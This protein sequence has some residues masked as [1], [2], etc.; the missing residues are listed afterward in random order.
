[1]PP[2][3]A[4]EVVAG[5]GTI[6]LEL[7]EELPELTTVLVPAGGG[8]L[9]AGVAV[10]VK[11]SRPDVRIVGVQTAAMPGLLA[12]RDGRRAR[13]GTAD[14]HRGGWRRRRRALGR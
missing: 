2:F 6:G 12:S 10:A 14:S 3:D 5:Q 1:M 7:L 11:S 9:L 4:P 13:R 8:G